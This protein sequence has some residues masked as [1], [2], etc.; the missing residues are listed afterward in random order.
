MTSRKQTITT[1]AERPAC[2]FFLTLTAC[3]ACTACAARPPTAGPRS[4]EIG[5]TL[6]DTRTAAAF[7]DATEPLG[8]MLSG[9]SPRPT[10][11]Q[12]FCVVGYRAA[13]GSQRAWAHWPEGRR[14]IL[15]E[16]RG[17]PGYPDTSLRHSRRDLD[18]DHDVVPTEPDIDGSTYLVT[19]AWVNAVLAD[20][21]LG[22]AQYRVSAARRS[23]KPRE[24]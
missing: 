15:W 4:A 6:F 9:V 5:M 16:G 8:V 24:D 13:D 20:C 14:L 11:P 7:G 17:E 19:R 12:T 23:E 22:G 21:A 18:L 3:A 10:A 2:V 1:R